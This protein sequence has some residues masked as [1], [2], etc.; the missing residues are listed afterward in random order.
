MDIITHKTK[1]D[2]GVY[3]YFMEKNGIA[4]GR[5]Y[6][7]NDQPERIF[8]DSLSIGSKYRGK[9]YGRQMQV[10][11]EKFGKKKGCKYSLLWV[12]KKTWMEKWYKKRGYEY[13]SKVKDNVGNIWMKKT[14]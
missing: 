6:I 9:G 12:K 3:F 8:L 5:A 4:F 2:W 7:Y 1:T 11:R 13:H 14:L 10:I